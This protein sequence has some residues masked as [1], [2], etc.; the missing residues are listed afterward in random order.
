MRYRLLTL[1]LLFGC[2]TGCGT[3]KWTDTSRTAT[4]QLLISDSV[5]RAVS[6]LDFRAIAGKKVFLDDSYVKKITDTDYLVSSLRQHIVASGAILK[7]KREE[8]DYI[9]EVR[10]GAVGTDHHDV[11]F[12]IPQTT[13]PSM[14]PLSTAG[15]TIPEIALAKRTD[16]RAVAKVAVFAYNRET[17][18]PIWQSGVVPSESKAKNFWIVGAGPFQRGDIYGGTKFAGTRLNIPLIDPMS[19]RDADYPTVS[20]AEQA[21]FSEPR[22]DQAEKPGTQVA[23][24]AKPAKDAAPGASPAVIQASHSKPGGQ[25]GAS[26]SAEPKASPAPPATDKGPSPTIPPAVT[27]LPETAPAATASQHIEPAAWASPA[28]VSVVA[29]PATLPFNVAPTEAGP[30]ASDYRSTDQL[31]P[32]PSTD[33]LPYYR[34]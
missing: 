24:S 23:K 28:G 27:A 5:D 34:R 15:T 19:A 2:G 33:P 16:Q 31:G 7:A 29:E 10:A 32:Y 12:G 8:A 18:R 20:V 14:L 11:L 3:T 22:E 6:Q 4:E 1:L 25:P 30:P 13:I 21:Y 17:G 26:P 9:V